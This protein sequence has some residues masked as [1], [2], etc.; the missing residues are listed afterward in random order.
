MHS[1]T[2]PVEVVGDTINYEIRTRE[3]QPVDVK[4]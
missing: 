2:T 4:F 3:T 1:A